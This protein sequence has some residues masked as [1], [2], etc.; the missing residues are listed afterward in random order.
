MNASG[1]WIGALLAFLAELASLAA[2]AFWGATVPA[3]TGLRLLAAIGLP[4]AAA[5]LWWFFAAPRAKVRVPALAGVTKVAVHGGAV[6]ALATTGH[7]FAAGVLGAAAV[8]GWLLT[9]L[10]PREDRPAPR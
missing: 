4:L 10:S 9:A 2:L 8:F 7:P 6:A 3:G 5:V 1:Y